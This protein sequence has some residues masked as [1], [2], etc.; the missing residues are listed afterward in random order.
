MITKIGIL[1]TNL[2]VIFTNIKERTPWYLFP[3]RFLQMILWLIIEIL[4]TNI[5]FSP[6]K[7]KDWQ[8]L[9]NCV[10]DI[11]SVLGSNGYHG[12]IM[13]IEESFGKKTDHLLQVLLVI[14]K[15]K[16]VE[17]LKIATNVKWA[18]DYLRAIQ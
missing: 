18:I 4:N 14:Q 8:E 6:R 15:Q 7:F 12:W 10:K 5:S 17:E 1:K 16:C 11:I 3:I 2:R 13:L 9:T